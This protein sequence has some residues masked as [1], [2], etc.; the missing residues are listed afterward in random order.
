VV[1][2]AKAPAQC[3]AGW[4]SWQADGLR[5]PPSLKSAPGQFHLLFM[6]KST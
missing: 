6:P 4:P 1:K 2:T 3:E 5:R